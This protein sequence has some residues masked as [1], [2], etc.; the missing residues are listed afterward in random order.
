MTSLI[1]PIGQSKQVNCFLCHSKCSK[2]HG[3]NKDL[4]DH[5][6]QSA[7]DADVTRTP[8]LADCWLRSGMNEMNTT[9][10]F[11]TQRGVGT[12]CSAPI[13]MHAFTLSE[14][15]KALHTH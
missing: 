8:T 1:R 4:Q 13:P 6:S 9:C 5:N 12:S 3:P 14:T 7:D 2:V 11:H 10:T 15:K